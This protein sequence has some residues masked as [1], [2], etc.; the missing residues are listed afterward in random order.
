MEFIY[1]NLPFAAH[2][3]LM[4]LAITGFT[5]P[6]LKILWIDPHDYQDV[7]ARAVEYLAVRGMRVSIYNHQLCV[8]RPH[9]WKY[10]RKSISDWKNMY[11]PACQQCAALERCG[12][13]FKSAAEQHSIHIHA[14]AEA[15]LEGLR[16]D[17]A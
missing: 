14:L 12:G 17:T 15:M 8:L 5:K 6:N 13:L 1:R 11:L 9:L 7:L 4:G 3:A 10:A 2:V 16:R